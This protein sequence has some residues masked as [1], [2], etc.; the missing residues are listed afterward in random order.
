MCSRR[1]VA[2]SMVLALALAL[3]TAA[4]GPAVQVGGEAVA[5]AVSKMKAATTVEERNAAWEELAALVGKG[6]P[7]GGLGLP[8]PGGPG[9]RETD[10]SVAGQPKEPDGELE[11]TSRSSNALAGAFRRASSFVSFTS[12]VANQAGDVVAHVELNGHPFDA[13]SKPG[14]VR[15]DGHGYALSV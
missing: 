5:K 9:D 15:V 11:L 7:A 10:M 13:R 3:P 2:L 12:R 6:D 8:A 14:S 4:A 1:K